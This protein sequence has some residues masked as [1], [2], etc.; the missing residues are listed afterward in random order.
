MRT[1]EGMSASLSM[2][3]AGERKGKEVQSNKIMSEIRFAYVAYLHV[4]LAFIGLFFL[5]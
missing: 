5:N 4:V 1:V 3:L 2:S